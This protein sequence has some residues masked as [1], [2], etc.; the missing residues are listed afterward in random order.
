MI[1]G[2]PRLLGVHPALWGAAGYLAVKS[3]YDWKV[4]SGFRGNDE[5]AA[6]YAIGRTSQIGRAT[7]TDA[8]VGTSAH[9][10]GLAIDVQP[11]ADKGASV[12]QDLQHP[13]WAEK[14]EILSGFP[15]ITPAISTS[16]GRDWPH[17]QVKDWQNQKDWKNTY[18]VV[19]ACVS[20]AA[21]LVGIGVT[22]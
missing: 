4:V 2:L 10:F 3:K 16:S 6:L 1:Y 7:V 14:D 8:Q 20:L 17:I 11:T 19:A 18:T 22:K 9:N 15:G 5:Q 12:I 13:A 21:I